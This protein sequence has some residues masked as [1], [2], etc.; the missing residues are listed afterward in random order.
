MMIGIQLISLAF[1][2]AAF[3]F[4]L[5]E[6]FFMKKRKRLPPGPKGLP[7]LGHLHMLGKNPHQDLCKLA[8]KH[9][10]IMHLQFG[11][12]PAIIV[13]SPEAA[14]KFL[15]TYDHVFASRPHHE[16]SWYVGYGQRNLTFGP[17]GSYW[18]NMRKLCIIQLLSKQKINSFLPMRKKEVGA[19]VESLKRAASDS[20]AVDLTA[21]ISSLGANMSCL[22]IFGKKYMDKDIGDR[23]FKHVIKEAMRMGAIPNLG[24]FFPGLGVLD[25]QGITRKMK[26]LSKVFDRFF[27]RIIDEHL[28]SKE[29]KEPKDFVDIMLEIM[30]SGQSEFKFDHRNIKAVL[31]DMLVA[32][33]D[34]SGTAVEW[35]LSELLRHPESMKK[36][37]K[38]LGEK[39]G[40]DRTV[41][42]TELESLEYLNMVL[43]ETMRLHPVGPLMLP[44]ESMEDCE[45][46][47]FRIP[48]KSRILV[49]I[50]AIGRDPNVW[51]DPERFMPE[52]FEKDDVDFRGQDF[53]LIPFGSGRRSCPGLHLGFTV[54]RFLLAQLVHCFDWKL[55]Y[56]IQPNEL[57]MSEVFG[58][59]TSRAQ[60]L[61]VIPKY[62]LEG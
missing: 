47:G 58:L 11:F 28:Q 52:R 17:Y 3:C 38:E 59:V 9:G 39:I 6:M 5:Q 29:H 7:I 32:T 19:L 20:S 1:F 4:L 41:E 18:R 31:L 43:K 61:R 54:F 51:P 46:D 22:M 45:V 10:P 56:D 37:Q 34:S 35:A 48:K 36:L 14:E 27:E 25:L 24:D 55:A 33:T 2:L 62:R 26:A 21:A 23:G 50:W 15:K 30:Q 53:R 12:V 49:N 44:H 13:S 57:D 42:E 60:P 16:S 8:R 40:M